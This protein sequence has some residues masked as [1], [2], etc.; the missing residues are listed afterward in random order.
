MISP[1]PSFWRGRRVLMT[2]HTGFKGSWLSLML[3]ELGA[4]LFGLALE[5]ESFLP[6]GYPL[7]EAL[8]LAKRLG[9]NHQIGDIRDLQALAAAVSASQ[10]QVVLHLAAQPLVRRS[11]SNPMG[12]WSTNVQGTLQLLETLR[13][14]KSPCA[15]VLISTDKV[16]ANRE[17][18]WGYREDDR[19]GGHD[20]YSASKAAMEL[21]VESWRSSFCGNA[22]HQSPYLAIATARAGN[23]IGGGDWAVDRIIPDAMRALIAGE[24]IQ[25]RHPCSTRP[26]QHVLEPLTGYLQLA[27]QLSEAPERHSQAYN[28]GPLVEANRSVQQLVEET[29]QHWSGPSSWLNASVAGASHESGCLNL[30]ADRAYKQLGWRSRWAFEETI[31]R[32]VSWYQQVHQGRQALSCC[33]EDLQAYAG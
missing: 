1:D 7:F 30:V 14:Y 17:W 12:T 26:W 10:P 22:P 31:E 3:L 32:T 28:F 13:P 25:L 23:V 19:L 21:M 4:E 15:V 24:P 33:L 20:P 16:Y 11:Y 27:E 29:L 8:G 5:P 6:P 2:G 9:A 18:E